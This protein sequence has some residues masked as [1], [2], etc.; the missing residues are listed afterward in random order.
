VSQQCVSRVFQHTDS[1][2]ELILNFLHSEMDF[3]RK[4]TES[5]RL[6]V[7]GNDYFFETFA[8]N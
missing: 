7:L 1:I 2:S 6:N 3:A 4:F 5:G 8:Q